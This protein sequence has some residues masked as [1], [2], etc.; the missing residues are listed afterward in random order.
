[1]DT[2]IHKKS[3]MSVAYRQF[4]DK[5][6]HNA[7]SFMQLL[8]LQVLGYLF[9]FSANTIGSGNDF[10]YLFIRNI[11]PIPLFTLTLIWILIQAFSLSG[12]KKREY[13]MVSNNFTAYFSD[14]AVLEVYALIAGI[15]MVFSGPMLQLLA[16]LSLGPFTPSAAYEA[17]SFIHYLSLFI[18]TT[19]YALLIGAGAY[20][21]G[22]LR[23]RYQSF[24]VIGGIVIIILLIAWSVLGVRF[25]GPGFS[26]GSEEL[27]SFYYQEGN[28]PVWLLK[29]LGS[30]GVL[31]Y[32]SWL[33]IRNLEVKN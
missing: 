19:F 24:F 2:T 8:A 32:L 22:I 1:M 23:I 17:M 18:T 14:I 33:G 5:L 31:Y 20:F 12:N 11:N 16:N 10:Y 30:I 9:S 4:K 6:Y 21:L 27:M 28:V 29:V 15:T 25:M 26:I 13:Y 3:K 7:F